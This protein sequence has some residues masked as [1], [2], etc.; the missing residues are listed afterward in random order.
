MLIKGR[1]W[2]FGDDIDTDQIYP[3]KYLPI[4][5]KK[6]MAKHAMEGAADGEDFIKNVKSGDIVVVGKNFGCGSSREHAA[7]AI[8]GCGVS[9][10]IAKSFARIF[11]RNCVNTGLPILQLKEKV[12]IKQGDI[13]EVNP[14]NGEIK[15][16]A[17]N[18]ILKAKAVSS[19][20]LEIMKAGGLLK[21]LKNHG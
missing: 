12:L 9:V 21:Y 2:I 17:Q 16:I 6:E 5:D 18:K 13:L 7:V 20:E 4:T 19:L 15:N 8:K 14:E 3:G 10:I 1:A 11:H